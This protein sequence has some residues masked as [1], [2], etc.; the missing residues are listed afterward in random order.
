MYY[1]KICSYLK[2]RYLLV[3]LLF[4]SV[5]A[6]FYT[7]QIKAQSGFGIGFIYGNHIDGLSLRYESIQIL[8]QSVGQRVEPLTEDGDRFY[9]NAALRYNHPVGSWNRVKFKVF[10]Q[11]GRES[12]IPVEGTSE[13]WRFSSGGAAEVPITRNSVSKGLFLGANVAFSIDHTG[14]L[15]SFPIAWGLGVHVHF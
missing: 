9:I 2:M 3:T 6:T 8:F 10:G 13:R 11:V 1:Y 7:P 14:D 4:L 5:I 12:V 15:G